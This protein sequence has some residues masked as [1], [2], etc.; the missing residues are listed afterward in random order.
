MSES[1]DEVLIY[2]GKQLRATSVLHTFYL[3]SINKFVANDGKGVERIAMDATIQHGNSGGP[4][5]TEDGY[6]IGVNTNAAASNSDSIVTEIDYYAIN[7]SELVRFL[8]KNN[9]PYEMAGSAGSGVNIMVISAI[10]VIVIAAGVIGVL[11]VMNNKKK[12]QKSPKAQSTN[13]SVKKAVIRSM[14][15]QHA[16]K[17]FPVG[18]AP[19]IIGRNAKE[20]VVVYKEETPG[21]SG[22]HCSIYYRSDTGVFTLTDLNSSYGTFLSNGMKLTA[23]SPVNLK[24]GDSFYVGDKANVI[25]VEVEQ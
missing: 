16:G 24:S 12:G 20:C 21:V 2:L 11:L 19:V 3:L 4:L 25:K 14:S 10:A 22:K 9:I 6:V 17:A 7:T 18:K 5:V 1:Q 8:D 15:A 13:T 23:N